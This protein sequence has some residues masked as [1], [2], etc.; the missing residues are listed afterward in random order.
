MLEIMRVSSEEDKEGEGRGRSDSP[1]S[2][3]IVFEV[4]RRLTSY[5]NIP[6]R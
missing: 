6:Y 3:G 4:G 1:V 2:I 5:R